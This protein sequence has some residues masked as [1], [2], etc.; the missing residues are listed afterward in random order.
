VASTRWR[1]SLTHLAAEPGCLA[2]E[3]AIEIWSLDAR[4]R[5]RDLDLGAVLHAVLE[6]VQ[7]KEASRIAI[8][9]A[10]V[11]K[12]DALL[13]IEARGDGDKLVA[14]RGRELADRR[15]SRPRY[16]HTPRTS[17]ERADGHKGSW[18]LSTHALSE[19]LA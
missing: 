12:I 6:G 2:V 1:C 3:P 15:K 13:V 4:L 19:Q 8:G 18:K 10:L 5:Q 11:R 17:G 16:T 9:L 7:Q 14:A